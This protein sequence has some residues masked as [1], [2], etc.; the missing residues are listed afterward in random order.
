MS[1]DDVRTE[2]TAGPDGPSIAVRGITLEV[3]KG[4]DAGAS[5]RVETPTFVVGSGD[6]ADLHISDKTV[7][8][9]HVTFAPTETGVTIRDEASRNGTWIGAVRVKE[10]H[11]TADVVLQIGGTTLAVR[12]DSGVSHLPVSERER[13]GGAI[14]VSPAI[15][16][17]FALLEKAART[18]VTVLLE[19]ESGVGKEVLAQGLHMESSRATEPFVP[20]DCTAIPAGLA[21][22]ELFGHVRGAFTGASGDHVGLVE[23]ADGGTLFLDELGELPL[24]IQAKLLRVLEVREVRPVGARASRKVDVRVVAATNKRLADAVQRGE[25][26][27]D[28]YYR[29]AVARVVVPPLRDRPEDIVPLATAFFRRTTGR[30]NAQLSADIVSMFR[31][32]RWPG[33]VREL[34]NVVERH[35]LLGLEEE[36]GLFDERGREAAR[37]QPAGLHE[38]VMQLDFHQARKI[39]LERFERAYLEQ[40]LARAGGVVTRAAEI[41]SVARPSFHRM[42]ERLGIDR[43][44]KA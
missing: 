31:A 43:E 23:Q 20:V 1:E 2:A 9:E 24:D 7:S 30:P 42:L 26:R 25:F 10:A 37:R 8:R 17:V 6:A 21:E 33:N 27:K 40:A 19:G 11:V 28:L 36:A 16:H 4:P 3:R 44:P 41:A 35:A 12:L 18:D 38:D 15:R 14:G 5:A 39:V 13:L 34:R 32:Y 29:L 22:S